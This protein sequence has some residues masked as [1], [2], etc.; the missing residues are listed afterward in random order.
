MDP[1]DFD[2]RLSYLL[3]CRLMPLLWHSSCLSVSLVVIRNSYVGYFFG[4]SSQSLNDRTG[5]SIN[6]TIVNTTIVVGMFIYALDK[7]VFQDPDPVRI[8]NVC[9]ME[10]PLI[11]YCTSDMFMAVCRVR[12]RSN[13]LSICCIFRLSRAQLLDLETRLPTPLVRVSW[14]S[15]CTEWKT[16]E[17]HVRMYA[18]LSESNKGGRF[19][20]SIFLL[21]ALPVFGNVITV[22]TSLPSTCR[23]LVGHQKD[24]TWLLTDF[25]SL[26]RWKCLLKCLDYG[27][28]QRAEKNVLVQSGKD[29]NRNELRSLIYSAGAKGLV[30][31]RLILLLSHKF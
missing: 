8:Q 21:L 9:V 26:R 29:L 31:L 27:V 5:R 20:N 13:I 16:F 25:G 18:A 7:L 1:Y 28:I 11:F 17:T 10:F 23:K 6:Q 14:S 2:P 22:L 12:V 19:L 24:L 3:P 30:T 15:G 4:M